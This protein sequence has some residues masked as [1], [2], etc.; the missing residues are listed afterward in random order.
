MKGV[1]Y[2][3]VRLMPGSEALALHEAGEHQKLKAHM[4]RLDAEA[5]AR[6]D[7]PYATGRFLFAGVDTGLLRPAEG[8]T[9]L[10]LQAAL[11]SGLPIV[12]TDVEMDPKRVQAMMERL[13]DEAA[14]GARRSAKL[15]G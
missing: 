11:R 12:I 6:G 1:V 15:Q 13:G 7:V 10:M 8:K 14:K 3:G 2:R 5:D 9:T 4:D